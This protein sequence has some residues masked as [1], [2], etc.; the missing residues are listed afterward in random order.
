M[1]QLADTTHDPVMDEAIAAIIGIYETAFPNRI[2]GYFLVGSLGDDTAISGSDIDME[3][4]FKGTMTA[5]EI[6]GCQVI[7]TSCRALSPIHLDLPVKAE[8]DFAQVDTVALKLASKF[9]YGEDA[10]D[11][12][13]LTPMDVY[14]RQISS[15]SHRGLTIRF[16]QEQVT[17]PLSYPNPDDCYFGYMPKRL[18]TDDAPT[19]LWVLNVGWLATFLIVH[20]ASVYVPSKRDMVGLYRQHIGD[21]W[22]EFI[23]DVYELGRNQWEYTIPEGDDYERFI[24]LCEQTLAFEN[25]VAAIYVDYLQGELVSGNEDF[26]KERLAAFKA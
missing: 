19:K 4:I 3:I 2:R 18:N 12:I 21:E 15:P 9:I 14:L 16:R 20:T 25:H 26:A 1:I 7:K 22:A 6:A 10:R 17:L 8:A 5:E 23:S 24:S 13:P 11:E